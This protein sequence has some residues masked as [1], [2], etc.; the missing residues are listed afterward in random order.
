MTVGKNAA[1]SP[2]LREIHLSFGG[3]PEAAEKLAGLIQA[4]KGE[5]ASAGMSDMGL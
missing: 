2:I 1:G 3:K 4:F 5:L